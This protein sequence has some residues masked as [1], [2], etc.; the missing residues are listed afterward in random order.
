MKQG[1]QFLTDADKNALFEGVMRS[2]GPCAGPFHIELDPIDACN[3]RCY[4][5]NAADLLK[6]SKL[7][8]ERVEPLLDQAKSRGLR[9]IRLAGGGEPTIY[10]NVTDILDWLERND[11][12]LDNLTTNGL[13]LSGD[14]A[15]AF[16]R[17]PPAYLNISL[18]YAT[19]T[20]YE[21]GMRV[22]ASKFDQAVQN[23]TEFVKLMRARG[24]GHECEVHVHFM[25]S[26][27]TLD[28]LPEMFKLCERMGVHAL[29]IRGVHGEPDEA[30]LTADERARFIREVTPLAREY[31]QR[32]WIM[33]A[34]RL[35]G[36]EEETS[37]LTDELYS[38]HQTSAEAAEQEDFQ[39][40]LMP[41]YSLAVLGVGKVYPCCILLSDPNVEPLGDLST[42][43]LD[44][45]WNGPAFQ[46]YRNEIRRSMIL[47]GPTP[48]HGS[49]CK[50]TDGLCWTSG[51]CSLA[52]SLPDPGSAARL[53]TLISSTRTSLS[54]RLERMQ[55]QLL[56]RGIDLA[57]KLPIG[58]GK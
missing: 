50:H 35:E 6:G 26:R 44:E 28:D 42:Q 47:G 22:P 18:N 14:L 4:F 3:A 34:L 29:S 31:S 24:K 55:F 1:W 11:V 13:R 45:V 12:R 8:W 10:P 33:F 37:R 48:M 16:A 20:S 46:R 2:E 25:L 19:A 40:C 39:Y 43:T 38:A 57:R 52:T 58:N 54:G 30:R 56:R 15:E 5:C 51:G 23:V 7:A 9:S 49:L 21:R 41:W 17:V 53:G 32:F 36:L 27:S